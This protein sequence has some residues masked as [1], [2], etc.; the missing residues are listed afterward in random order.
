MT[1][2]PTTFTARTPDDVLA[3]VPVVLGFVPSESVAMLTFGAA[4][5]FHARVDLPTRPAEVPEVVQA[6]LEPARRHRVRRAV[7]IVYAA[8]AR[9][10]PNVSMTTESRGTKPRTIGTRASRSSGLRAVSV[11]VG[12]MPQRSPR[13]PTLVGAPGTPCGE[14]LPSA[15]CGRKVAR[16]RTR[17]RGARVTGGPG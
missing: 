3:M 7:F 13:S 14:P 1:A 4:R 16:R 6:L 9:A 10:A 12:V 11:V 17:P 2:A 15:Q 5:P 8:D